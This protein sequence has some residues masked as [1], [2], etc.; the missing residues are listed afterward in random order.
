VFDTLSLL[1]PEIFGS[2]LTNQSTLGPYG[3]LV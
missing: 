1:P 3:H 2:W